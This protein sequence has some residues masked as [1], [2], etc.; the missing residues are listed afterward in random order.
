MKAIGTGWSRDITW[1]DV[2]VT[3]VPGGRPTVTFHCKAAKF[4]HRRGVAQAHLS[5]TH[6]Q[7]KRD[8]ACHPGIRRPWQSLTILSGRF[9]YLS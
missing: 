5:I 3:R 8:G 2:E 9:C 6:T 4:L 7:G 1:Q